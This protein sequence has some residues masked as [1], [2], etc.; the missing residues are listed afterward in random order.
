MSINADGVVAITG[1]VEAGKTELSAILFGLNPPAGGTMH[2]QGAPYAPKSPG[3]A[4]ETGVFL[5]SI[6]RATNGVLQDRDLTKNITIPFL[7]RYSV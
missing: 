3:H 6:Y 1:L 7:A 2:L 4:I 5:C